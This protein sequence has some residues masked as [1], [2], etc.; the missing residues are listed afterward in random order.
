MP[1]T[2]QELVAESIAAMSALPKGLEFITWSSKLD[3]PLVD[4]KARVAIRHAETSTLE[5]GLALL[6]KGGTFPG[7]SSPRDP[8]EINALIEVIRSELKRRRGV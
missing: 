4:P 7:E 1:K 2:I 6:H 8:A 3:I 5:E